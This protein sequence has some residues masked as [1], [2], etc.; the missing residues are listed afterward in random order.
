MIKIKNLS[1][2]FG[3]LKVLD[4]L[5]LH[6]GYGTTVL[7]GPSGSGKTTL[8]RLIAG[9]DTDFTGDIDSEKMKMSFVFQEDRILPWKTLR[10][11]IEFILPDNQVDSK[12][13]TAITESLNI[14]ELLDSRPFQ[15][16]GGQKRRGAIARGFIYPSDIILMDE[17][18]SSLD[19]YLKLK[20]I[21]DL[22]VLLE[23]E[24]RNLLLVT[25]DINEAL[26]LADEIVIFKQT[27]VSDFKVLKLD[28]PK[29]ERKLNNKAFNEWER[30]IYQY[31]LDEDG[32]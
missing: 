28:L 10:Q 2:S 19:L 4:K 11:N 13:I 15:L 20:I 26:L 27:P 22:N 17:P 8:L 32:E 23:R 25:H 12:R 3:D 31:L 7:L 16:S 18:F 1:K 14:N 29:S 6:I 30:Q 5:D 21:S 9:L 24:K